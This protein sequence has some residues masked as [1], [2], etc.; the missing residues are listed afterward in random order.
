MA[1]QQENREEGTGNREEENREQGRGTEPESRCTLGPRIVGSLPIV[2]P[3]AIS[4]L[5]PVFLSVPYSAE[6]LPIPKRD[7]GA[8]IGSICE[9]APNP[10]VVDITRRP[11][12][13]MRVNFLTQGKHNV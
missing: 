13:K 1:S 10:S 8:K 9:K 5:F 4:F 3:R 7:S 6:D 11:E 12:A 2:L